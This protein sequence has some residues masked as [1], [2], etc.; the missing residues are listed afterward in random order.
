LQKLRV[1]VAASIE[2]RELLDESLPEI[3]NLIEELENDNEELLCLNETL[4]TSSKTNLTINGE[5]VLPEFINSTSDLDNV[6]Q[7]MQI[8]AEQCQ[9]GFIL[10]NEKGGII[11]WNQAEEQITGLNRADVLDLS[12]WDIL[13]PIK[14]TTD[15]RD[16]KSVEEARKAN[17][18]DLLKHGKSPSLDMCEEIEI[19]CPDGTHGNI[20]M[21]IYVI[22]TAK[23][24]MLAIISRNIVDLKQAEGLLETITQ[25]LFDQ[26]Q[27][28]TDVIDSLPSSLVIINQSLRIISVNNNFLNKTGRIEQTTIGQKLEELF[29]KAILEYTRL[30]EHI[31]EVFKTG[32]NCNIGKVAYHAP[33]I[34]NSLFYFRVFPIFDATRSKTGK[35]S[36]DKNVVNVMLLMDDITERE[37][38]KKE[39]QRIERHLSSVVNCTNELITSLDIKGNI[40][41][42]NRAAEEFSGIKSDQ[43]INLPLVSFISPDHQLSLNSLLVIDKDKSIIPIEANLVT[44]SGTELPLSWSCSIMENSFGKA[45]GFVVV[46]RDLTEYN[47]MQE[48]LFMS[49]KMAFLGKMAG[50]IAHELR[51]PL[52]IISSNAQL[53]MEVPEE[54][55]LGKK[56]LENIIKA[57]WRASSIIETL[58]Q[59]GRP[60][61]RFQMTE[62]YLPELIDQSQVSIFNLIKT[63]DINVTV[64]CQENLP[65]II[66]SDTMLGQVFIN[67]IT[68][69]CN[70]MPEGG[71]LNIMVEA[72]SAGKVDI[73]FVDTGCGIPSENLSKIFEP[74]FSTMPGGKGVG[75]GLSLCHTI[76]KQHHGEIK[77]HSEI[78]KGS[79]FTVR[80]P[81]SF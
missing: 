34:P 53:T 18:L 23:G 28:L 3:L 31:S 6:Q 50:G 16:K 12:I 40:L 37:N 75:M 65:Q 59:I 58:L 5:S 41:S 10:V 29:P 2:N 43:A 78:G 11:E 54:I 79:R 22:P 57:S 81:V 55:E 8:F 33:G 44:V 70:A 24:Y 69:A 32:K 25:Q 49:R 74:F 4:I 64:T 7:T 17:F 15:K 1:L 38:I 26:K 47:R 19:L 13:S 63:H 14:K 61:R 27:L 42:W 71:S 77:V 72:K 36:G 48:E 76:I 67:L 30:T 51:N 39:V 35:Y 68:N 56:C 20:Q 45:V 73:H 66:G 9:D 60:E 62:I 52:A 80:L 21:S 46:G